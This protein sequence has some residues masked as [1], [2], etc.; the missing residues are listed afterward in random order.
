MKRIAEIQ[1]EPLQLQRLAAQ[2]QLYDEARRLQALRFFLAIPVAIAW[3]ILANYLWDNNLVS[4]LGSG[5]LALLNLYPFTSWE[6]AYRE[7]AAKIQELFDCEVLQMPR[8]I[9]SIGNPP[10]VPFVVEY[11]EK[12]DPRNY[13]NQP[14]ENWYSGPVDD[15]PLP[16][17]RIVCQRSNLS[18]DAQL[19]R[20]YVRGIVLF[21]VLLAALVVAAAW[22]LGLEK[23]D[24]LAYIIASLGPAASLGFNEI[25]TNLTAA[26]SLERLRQRMDD[27]WQLAFRGKADEDELT[28]AARNWQN[29]IFQHRKNSPV[30]LRRIYNRFRDLDEEANYKGT[31]ALVAEAKR[32]LAERDKRK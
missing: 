9:D 16:F 11:A 24:K 22:L 1:N 19:R 5:V 17:A 7:K 31:D 15:L 6:A 18:W 3:A 29:D 26:S 28:R 21:L 32:L 13:P 14:L 27:L 12:Y 30:L 25:K 10:P 8:N 4:L 20:R 2:R 23:L